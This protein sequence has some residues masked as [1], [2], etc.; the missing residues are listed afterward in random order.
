MLEDNL[1]AFNELRYAHR[2][3]CIPDVLYD[4]RIRE[5]SIMTAAR[6]A[7]RVQALSVVVGT[8]MQ[9]LTEREPPCFALSRHT[10]NSI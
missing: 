5:G 3:K 9:N 4:R 8:M 6:K 7:D 1:F 2:V 10:L